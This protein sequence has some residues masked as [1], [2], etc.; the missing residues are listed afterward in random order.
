MQNIVVKR[1]PHNLDLPLPAYQTTGSA[2]MDLP[3]AVEVSVTIDPGERKLIPTGLS[4]AVPRGF[5]ALVCSRSGLAVK[6][7]VVVLLAPGLIDSDYRGE[8][9]IV[10]HNTS[11]REA[12]VVNRGD[13][14]AQLMITPVFQPE[15]HE[16]EELPSS[17][18]GAGGFGSTGT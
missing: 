7:G 13:R 15:W 17:D 18:R 16:V 1:L 6:N 2:G 9:M 3:A 11:K 5:V 12:F 10:L 4:F 8:L 14:I